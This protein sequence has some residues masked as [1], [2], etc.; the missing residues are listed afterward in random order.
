MNY[1]CPHCGHDMAF[2]MSAIQHKRVP[3]PGDFG[4]CSG[5]AQAVRFD[6]KD[7]YL[8]AVNESDRADLESN[9]E[10]VKGILAAQHQFKGPD[11]E[12]KGGK[13]KS[14]GYYINAINGVGLPTRAKAIELIRQGAELLF[15]V[16][17]SVSE[18]PPGKALICVIQNGP[19]DAAMVVVD[20]RELKVC[21]SDPENRAKSWLM[22]D[23]R[24]AFEAANIKESP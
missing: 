14:M 10:L 4:V 24:A 8:R 22:M 19:F 12:I 6:I 7:G 9:A 15:I 16:P 2:E 17:D 11:I 18:V 13:E 23:R 5:C 21:L 20:D 3:K 1:L